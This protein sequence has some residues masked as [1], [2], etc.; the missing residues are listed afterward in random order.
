MRRLP[1]INIVFLLSILL[2]YNL[3]LCAQ[4]DV[5]GIQSGTWSVD[6]SPYIVKSNIVIPQGLLLKIEAGVV[7]KFAGNCQ[8]VVR[9]ALIARGDRTKPIIFT[10]ILDEQ[11][12]NKVTSKLKIPQAGDWQG[13]EFLDESDDYTTVMDHC[14]IRYSNW[15][16]HCSSCFPLLTNIIFRDI[17]QHFLRINNREYSFEAG[18]WINPI[19][20]ESRPVIVPL[21]EPAPATD[22]GQVNR[23]LEQQ[24]LKLE[25]IRLKSQQDSIRLA[26]K[27][28]P[29][30]TKTGQIT[31]EN[32]VFGQFNDYSIEGLISH[33]PGLL[34]IATPWTGNQVTGR[35][36]PPDLTNNRILFKIN[37]IPFYEPIAKTSYLDFIPLDGIARIEIDR[38]I[39]LSPFNHHGIA[40]SMNIIPQYKPAGLVNKSQLELGSFG[41]KK[42][43]GFLG[44]NRDATFLS[45]STGFMYNSGYWRTLSREQ[46]IPNFRQ[47]YASDRYH[48]SLFL[49]RSSSEL[50]ISCYENEQFQLGLIPQL[51]YNSPIKRRGLALSM[52][53]VIKINPQ[54][55]GKITTNYVHSYERSEIANFVQTDSIASAG[56]D[57]FLSK[58]NLLSVSM[59]SQYKQPGY[60]ATAGATFSRFFVNPLL[61]GSTSQGEVIQNE[62][63]ATKSRLVKYESTS[64]LGAGYNFSPFFGFNGTAYLQFINSFEEPGISVDA[65]IIYNPLLPFDSYVKFSLASRSATLFERYSYFPGFISGTSELKREKFQQWEWCT[66]IHVRQDLKFGFAFYHSKNSN[67]IQLNPIYCFENDSH[68]YRTTGGEFIL[69]GKI[70]DRAFIL[71]SVSYN[72]VKS[73]GWRFPQLKI[74]CLAKIHWLRKISTMTTI[75]YLSQLETDYRFGPYYVVSLFLT[76]QLLPRVKISLKGF[77]L[78]DQHPENPEYIRGEIAA[79]PAG[80]GRCFCVS[81]TIE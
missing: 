23:L 24:K 2:L 69:Q 67:V 31:L 74:N 79:I 9:G 37:N 71:T 60:R 76:Y 66:D 4:S 16:I 75:Q 20:P 72:D 48:L 52:S 42:L 26:N 6:K 33:L 10:S 17:E 51:Q 63:G 34:N 46:S 38:G 1:G 36:V 50:F 13:V 29:I 28:K 32:Q 78:L 59:V 30:F 81:T 49:K 8:L 39:A 57:Y 3:E 77:D 41:T 27:V 11:F 80:A 25:Q 68:V 12:G 47:K 14:I 58:G 22:P 35:G 40:G 19:P 44:L 54:L 73:S 5:G 15:G 55:E 7:V 64:F 45:L 53:K 21:P 70:I 61:E 65:K 18:Q 43:S 56:V 62:A